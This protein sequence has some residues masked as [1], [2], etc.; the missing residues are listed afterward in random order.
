MKDKQESG[1]HDLLEAHRELMVHLHA[2]QEALAPAEKIDMPRLQSQLQTV[3]TEV[4]EH[5]QFEEQGGY[6]AVVLERK[7]QLKRTVEELRQ[8]HDRLAGSLQELVR[9]CQHAITIEPELVAEIQ[10]WMHRLRD[11]E[12]RENK[13]VQETFNLETGA[14]D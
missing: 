2:L 4:K 9:H 5:F 14:G 13:L 1:S 10:G 7:P 6:L 8:E 3:Q 12:A 11:H